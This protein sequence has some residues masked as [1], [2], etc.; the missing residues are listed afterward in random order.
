[1]IDAG[2]ADAWS[3]THPGELGYTWGHQEDLRNTTVNFDRRLD[4]VLFCDGRREDGLCASGADIVGDELLLHPN[5]PNNASGPLW[6][7]DHAGVVAT[8]R[9]E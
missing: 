5:D 1:L 6:P 7:S 9:V 4:L 3:V 2:F 8:L